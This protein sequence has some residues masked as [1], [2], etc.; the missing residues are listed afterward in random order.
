[1][2]YYIY[3]IN[4]KYYIYYINTKYYNILYKYEIL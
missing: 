1:M 3:Y 4:T 2:K